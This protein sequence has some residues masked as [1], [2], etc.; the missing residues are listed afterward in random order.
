MNVDKYCEENPQRFEMLGSA[1]KKLAI[2]NTAI[3]AAALG[4]ELPLD[5]ALDDNDPWRQIAAEAQRSVADG[6]M[7]PTPDPPAPVEPVT[8]SRETLAAR[9]LELDRH[10]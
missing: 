5:F 3:T 10:A 8:D 4:S 6:S 2:E 7:T 1:C 9:K